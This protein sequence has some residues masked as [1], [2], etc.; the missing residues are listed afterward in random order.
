MTVARA[1]GWQVH[2]VGLTAAALGLPPLLVLP[3]AI[4]RGSRIQTG[5]GVSLLGAVGPGGMAVLVGLL[6]LLALLSA[7]D[8]RRPAAA[9]GRGVAASA[10]IVAVA[11]LSGEAARTLAAEVGPFARVSIGAGAW[12]AAVTAYAAVLASRRELGATRP[13]G[14]L[15]ASL[16]PAGVAA[17]LLTGSLDAL[18]IMREYA[19][20]KARFL[21]EVS[22]HVTLSAVSVGLATAIGV[23][24]GV[25]AFRWR[26]IERPAFVSVS[27]MQTIPGLAMIGLLVTPLA[28]LSRAVPWLREFGFGGL[29][30]APVVTALTLYALLPV[31]RNTYAGL[32]GVPADTVEAGFGMGMSSGQVLRRVRLPL[33]APVLSSGVRI[34]AVQTVGNATL[35]AFAAAGTLGLFVFGGLAQQSTD[36]IM[37]GSIAIVVLAV[38]TDGALRVL[39]RLLSPRR[40]N[41]GVRR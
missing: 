8:D 34:A 21:A 14:V 1:S 9:A 35:G 7:R 36:L 19:N 5:E 31:V 28:S 39:Q 38:V 29:G 4:L 10:L 41:T 33:A 20:Q 17:L 12:A 27:V 3:F 37:L 15:I 23:A 24:I 18:G 30:W 40:R 32:S 22:G 26:G 25:A 6:L 16:A 13:L 2:K 11:A